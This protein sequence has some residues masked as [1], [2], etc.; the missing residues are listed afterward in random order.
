MLTTRSAM[1][2][3]GRYETLTLY[4]GRFEVRSDT[5][6]SYSAMRWVITTPFGRPVVPEV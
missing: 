4:G 2:A 1:C 5:R 6:H 3:N